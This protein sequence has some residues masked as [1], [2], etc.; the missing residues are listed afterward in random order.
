MPT[1][2]VRAQHPAM[3]E[4]KRIRIVVGI[5]IFGLVVSGVAVFPLLHELNLLSFLLVGEGPYQA[6]LH[7]GLVHCENRETGVE[8]SRC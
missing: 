1:P 4:L 8:N 6:E 3:N 7:S 2:A 5:V